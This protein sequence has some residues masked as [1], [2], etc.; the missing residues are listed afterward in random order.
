MWLMI[1]LLIPNMPVYYPWAKYLDSTNNMYIYLPVTRDIVRNMAKIDNFSFPWYS[2][3]GF[4]NG[5]VDCIKVKKS[6]NIGERDALANNRINPIINFTT[7]GCKVFGQKTLYD[8]DDDRM[9]LT[10]IAIRRLMLYVRKSVVDALNPLVFDQYDQ[11]EVDKVYGLL[12]NIMSVIKENRGIVQYKIE[13]SSSD[14]D[15]DRRKCQSR[16]GSN[17]PPRLSTSLSTL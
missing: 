14:E 8:A 7:D 12:N 1:L 9:P 5:N 11:T 2:P 4:Q 13:I 16:Y 15:K 6:L 17:L 10:R 3:A